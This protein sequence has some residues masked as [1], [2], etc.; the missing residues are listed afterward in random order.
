[1][2]SAVRIAFCAEC[3]V[4]LALGATMGDFSCVLL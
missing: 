1:M 3:V 2:P 4:V